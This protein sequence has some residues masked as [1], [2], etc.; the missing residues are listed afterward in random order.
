MIKAVFIDVDNTLLSFTGYVKQAMKEGFA[1]YG[2]RP[3]EESMYGTFE[4]INNGLWEQI[5]QG[6][7]T[8]EELMKIRWNRIF[9]ALGISFDGPVFEQF[10]REALYDSAIPEPGAFDLLD[11]LKGRYVLC[12]ASNGPYEQQIHRLKIAGMYEHFAHCFISEKVGA[13]KPGKAFFDHCFHILRE[14]DLPGLHPEE[15][16]IIGDS[17]TSDIAGGT[18]YGMHTCLYL[19]GR[20]VSSLKARGNGDAGATAE[21]R[22]SGLADIRNIL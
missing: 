13:Q 18:A 15:T 1:R 11:Y 17:M 12:A 2:L 10:F 7:L 21:Y 22:I 16:M 20:E 8:F 14:N 3:Y 6:T 9:D 4:M 19:R 5:E